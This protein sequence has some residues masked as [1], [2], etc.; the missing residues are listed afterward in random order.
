MR[1]IRNTLFQ[2]EIWHGCS[3]HGCVV[4]G[5]K[6]GMG[7]NGRCHCVSSANRQQLNFLQSRIQFL[8]SEQEKETKCHD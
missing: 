5:N 7:A 1:N 4:T 8:I 3:N 2:S 6:K